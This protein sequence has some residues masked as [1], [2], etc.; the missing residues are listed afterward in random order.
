[1]RL[2]RCEKYEAAA[3]K[4]MSG[5]CRVS[6]RLVKA[7]LTVKIILLKIET[8]FTFEVLKAASRWRQLEK[9]QKVLISAFGSNSDLICYIS[10]SKA[11]KFLIYF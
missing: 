1:L 2:S 7:K 8:M 10:S 4:N 5:W 9:L 6:T 3:A 11:I